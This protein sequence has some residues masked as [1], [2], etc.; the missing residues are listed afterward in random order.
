MNTNENKDKKHKM[1]I[2]IPESTYQAV[3]ATA[4]E[5]GISISAFINVAIADK[6]QTYKKEPTEKV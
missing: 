5:I 6:L 2:L 3:K 4:D 1:Q